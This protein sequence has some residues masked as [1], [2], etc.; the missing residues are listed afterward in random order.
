MI[1][2]ELPKNPDY[3]IS[4]CGTELKRISTGK[5]VKQGKQ[6]IKGKQTGYLYATL[7][8]SYPPTRMAVH[9]LVAFAHLSDPLPG[10]IW[11][12]HKDGNKS[13]NHKNNLEWTTISENIQHAYKTGL[14]ERPKGLNHW[15]TGTKLSKEAK[16]KMSI[17]KTGVNH[18]KFKG[19]YI[20]NW[21]RYESASAAAKALNTNNK[22]IIRWCKDPCKRLSGFYFIPK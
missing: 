8:D 22:K 19:Y 6:I 15:K 2:K 9:R 20:A 18:P 14:I 5:I 4:E 11:I 3:L 1:Y 16:L 7:C 17:Q 10:Q 21:K 13:N 12:N